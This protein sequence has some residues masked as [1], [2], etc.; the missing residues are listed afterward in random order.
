MAFI[1][2]PGGFR[3]ATGYPTTNAEIV[4]LANEEAYGDD[5]WKK[6]EEWTGFTYK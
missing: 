2:G 5:A 3:E 1:V 4:G 6:A